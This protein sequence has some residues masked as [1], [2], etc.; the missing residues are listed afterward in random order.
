MDTKILRRLPLQR[1]TG[2][3]TFVVPCPSGCKEFSHKSSKEPFVKP[4]CKIRGNVRKER[5]TPRL[6]PNSCS[7]RR[8]DHRESNLHTKQIFLVDRGTY[9]DSVPHEIDNACKATRSASS[10]RDGGLADRVLKDTTITKRQLDLA[11]RMM[12]GTSFAF[13]KWGSQ[14]IN[15][16]PTSPGLR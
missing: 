11:A 7:Q 10:N 6:D 13:V 2:E 1:K 12:L 5:R 4:T 9:N 3:P 16:A 15:N 8:S 14:T